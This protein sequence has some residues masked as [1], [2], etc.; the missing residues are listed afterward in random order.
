MSYGAPAVTVDFEVAEW[1][2]RADRL[3]E[4]SP[5]AVLARWRRHLARRQFE[6]ALPPLEDL[7][8][9]PL[10]VSHAFAR[11]VLEAGTSGVD[12]GALAMPSAIGV[13]G[14]LVVTEPPHGRE[15][16]AQAAY[17][18]LAMAP[19]LDRLEVNASSAVDPLVA[20][21]VKQAGG[22]LVVLA[23]TDAERRAMEEVDVRVLQLLWQLEER[24]R[25]AGARVAIVDPASLTARG[26]RL[27]DGTTVGAIGW[28]SAPTF[29][30]TVPALPSRAV[31]RAALPGLAA[32]PR[33][34][35][36]GEDGDFKPF[37]EPWISQRRFE[38][39][40]GSRGVFQVAP[41]RPIVQL[42][43]LRKGAI[44]WEPCPV[45]LSVIGLGG[46]V[47][48]AFGRCTRGAG[49]DAYDFI[50]PAVVLR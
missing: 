48:A 25:Q 1:V 32:N 26:A 12:A 49:D 37:D 17:L 15:W 9:R 34:A 20:E 43:F 31:T 30:T 33:Y 45:E 14:S 8:L 46:E 16:L 35:P 6:V 44:A 13:P 5:Q 39:T 23:I 40:D 7:A 18:D 47:I 2:T 3:L 36:L 11:E 24:L 38:V 10:F 41:P 27:A 28:W 21:L 22:G 4:T 29:D 50:C 19:W 42:P